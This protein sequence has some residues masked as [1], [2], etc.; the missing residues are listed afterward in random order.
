MDF[1]FF[2]KVM[3]YLPIFTVLGESSCYCTFINC[4]SS[5][6]LVHNNRFRDNIR[7][8]DRN[9]ICGNIKKK[10]ELSLYDQWPLL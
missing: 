4:I 2:L 3:L 1:Q 8:C 6:S 5:I 9:Y 7:E 10:N